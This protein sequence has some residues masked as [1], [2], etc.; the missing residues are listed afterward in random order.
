MNDFDGGEVRFGAVTIIPDRPSIVYARVDEPSYAETY[1]QTF[2][3][4]GSSYLPAGAKAEL[5]LKVICKE[6]GSSEIKVILSPAGFDPI[7]FTFTKLCTMP[8]RR[9][10]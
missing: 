9:R 8:M 10:S 4:A 5:R 6:A 3:S 2:L 7:E 1:V